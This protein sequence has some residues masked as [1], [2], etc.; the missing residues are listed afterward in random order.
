M[1]A[2][3]LQRGD[4]ANVSV[5][6]IRSAEQLIFCFKERIDDPAKRER[7]YYYLAPT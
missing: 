7:L 6:M 2:P 3:K 4:D 5:V 1:L